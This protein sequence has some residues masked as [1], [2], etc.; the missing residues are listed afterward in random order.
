MLVDALAI[1]VVMKAILD[2]CEVTDQGGVAVGG[3]DE[4]A[5]PSELDEL[6]S[7]TSPTRRAHF[8]THYPPG[9]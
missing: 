6:A 4:G 7:V 3:R 8:S 9:S 1:Y 5:S 2:G